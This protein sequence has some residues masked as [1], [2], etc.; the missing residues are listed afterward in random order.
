V[1]KRN[2]QQSALHTRHS[3]KQ[4]FN[5]DDAFNAHPAQSACTLQDSKRIWPHWN[6]TID[7]EKRCKI[8]KIEVT[9]SCSHSKIV[10]RCFNARTQTSRIVTGENESHSSHYKSVWCINIKQSPFFYI[11]AF[12]Y[13]S[14][15]FYF[16]LSNMFNIFQAYI[17]FQIQNSSAVDNENSAHTT[18][19]IQWLGNL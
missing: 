19:L 7:Q 8:Q 18:F 3:R 9:Q 14:V 16:E 12:D 2:L 13:S 6:L 11:S 10:Q 15:K 4:K 1:S 17:W 5:T